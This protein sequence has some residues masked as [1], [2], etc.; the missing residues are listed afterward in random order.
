MNSSTLADAGRAPSPDGPGPAD[1]CLIVYPRGEFLSL[2]NARPVFQ[3]FGRQALGDSEEMPAMG[4]ALHG[5]G[6]HYYLRDGKHN[7]TLEDWNAYMDFADRFYGRAKSGA[8]S[9][10]G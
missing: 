3:L 1:Y 2:V 10:K 6:A 5:D 7:L 4:E 9:K 8:K